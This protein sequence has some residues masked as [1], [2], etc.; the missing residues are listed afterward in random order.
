MQCVCGTVLA[1]D[2]RETTRCERCGVEVPLALRIPSEVPVW[3][4]PEDY[5]KR[6]RYDEHGC[7]RLLLGLV[8]VRAPKTEPRKAES[9]PDLGCT[10]P[11][12][13]C[14][15]SRKPARLATGRYGLYASSAR[16]GK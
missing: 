3:R 14:N 5:F 12:C 4:L 6:T 8:P 11:R 2:S 13:C 7:D 9:Q 16:E 1:G 10:Y 15:K